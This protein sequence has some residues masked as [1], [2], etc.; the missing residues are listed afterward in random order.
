M[1]A[2]EG[3]SADLHTKLPESTSPIASPRTPD[4]KTLKISVPKDGTGVSGS[5]DLSASRVLSPRKQ[6]EYTFPYLSLIMLMLMAIARRAVES[7]M[8]LTYEHKTMD[9]LEA[10]M[11]IVNSA[12]NC[13][14]SLLGARSC[15]LPSDRAADGRRHVEFD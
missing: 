2:L 13:M 4:A 15:N 11:P 10:R 7:A 14:C 3:Y 9:L 6:L 12:N 1:T 5:E 8:P